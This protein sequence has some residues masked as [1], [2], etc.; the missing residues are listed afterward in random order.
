[1]QSEANRVDNLDR[2]H[3]LAKTRTK[4]AQKMEAK[5]K[6]LTAQL[7]LP[8]TYDDSSKAMA[9]NRELMGISDALQRL[10]AEWEESVA[11]LEKSPA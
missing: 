6:E 8:G 10:S 4:L 5:Q 9:L 7:E 2:S 3:R 1:M 11:M